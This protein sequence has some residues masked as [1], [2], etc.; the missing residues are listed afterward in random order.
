MSARVTQDEIRGYGAGEQ[1]LELPPAPRKI[2]LP[3]DCQ[4]AELGY[5]GETILTRTSM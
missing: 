4:S 3:K 5:G 2:V 1:K